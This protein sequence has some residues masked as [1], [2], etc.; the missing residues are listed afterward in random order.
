VGR[1][2]VTFEGLPGNT[3]SRRT[4]YDRLGMW[5]KSIT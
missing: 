3:R 1:L 4:Y 2:K 5:G